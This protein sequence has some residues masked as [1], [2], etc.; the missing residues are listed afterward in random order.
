MRPI[1]SLA[2]CLVLAS[3]TAQAQ[4]TVTRQITSEPVET[5][6][7]QGPDGAA[8]T[9]RILTPEPGI[10]VAVPAPVAETETY[11]E[12]VPRVTTH[13]VTTTRR[14]ATRRARVRGATARTAVT[15]RTV[16]TVQPAVEEAV[17]LTPAQRQIVYR[18]IA[19][20]AV[21]AAPIV[22][23]AAPPVVAE[24][25]VVEP[26]YPL[27]SIYPADNSYDAYGYDRDTWAWDSRPVVRA[28][29]VAVNYVVGSRL[30]QN[31]PLVGVPNS[32]ALQIPSIAPYSYA[33]VGNRVYLVDPET[34]VIVADVTR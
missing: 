3:G 11:V 25:E 7:T 14:V 10:T 5:V 34:S 31:V 30:P 15:T 19:P 21:Y 28:A 12:P 17:V 26:N 32:L 29:P 24:T 27:R 33:M 9:R 1:G 6:V 16:R 4:T 20:R 18:T 23:P 2:V 13:R 22:A 8:V